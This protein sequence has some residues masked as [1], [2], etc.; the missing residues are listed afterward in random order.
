MDDVFHFI[1]G[2]ALILIPAL[3][4]VGKILKELFIFPDRWIPLFLLPIGIAG[5]VALIGCC[6]EA[7][8]QGVLVT[9]TAVYGNQIVKQINKRS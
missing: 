1:I 7:V 3:M 2:D 8:V 5:T 9:S 4:I 6:W